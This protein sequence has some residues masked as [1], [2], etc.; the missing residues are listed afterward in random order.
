MTQPSLHAVVETSE[1]PA[2]WV[3][4]PPRPWPSRVRLSAETPPEHVA[5]VVHV[6]AVYNSVNEPNAAPLSLPALAVETEA[7]LPGGLA[8]VTDAESIIPGCC[9]GLEEWREWH[10]LLDGSGSPFLGHDP[11]PYVE[12]T[13]TG[14]IVWADGGLGEVRA[15]QTAQIHFS[16]QRLAAALAEVHADLRGF[17]RV[18]RA[19]CDRAVP[20]H[21]EG[22]VAA[23]AESFHISDPRA[24]V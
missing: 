1:G 2:S 16:P 8:A 19:W 10:S 24:G 3:S 15:E 18:L 12:A 9:S 21:A 4:T 13:P 14:F 6:L 22:I 23:F 17:L 7:V 11:A 5:L 20:A